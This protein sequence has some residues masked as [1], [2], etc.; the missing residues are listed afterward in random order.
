[1]YVW[2]Q[3]EKKAKGTV[4]GKLTGKKLQVFYGKKRE[5]KIK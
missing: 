4:N 2:S 5:Q 3:N 1:M